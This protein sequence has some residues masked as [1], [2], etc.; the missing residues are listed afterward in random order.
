MNER[1]GRCN[2]I[3][4]IAQIH[5]CVSMY[6]AEWSAGKMCSRKLIDQIIKLY[7]DALSTC[8]IGTVCQAFCTDNPDAFRAQRCCTWKCPNSAPWWCHGVAPHQNELRRHSSNCSLIQHL[9]GV[10]SMQS[11]LFTEI[12]FSNWLCLMSATS[13]NC[14]ELGQLIVYRCASNPKQS[15]TASRVYTNT[16]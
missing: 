4:C 15:I 8:A 14:I 13:L 1:Q 5:I 11:F 9:F 6:V 7:R 12:S 16:Y 3:D 2:A 10:N